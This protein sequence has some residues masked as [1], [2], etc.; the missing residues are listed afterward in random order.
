M[1]GNAFTQYIGLISLHRSTKIRVKQY[2]GDF[3]NLHHT[4]VTWVDLTDD[5]N[6]KQ[7]NHHAAVGQFLAIGQW[8][9]VYCGEEP[10]AT[11]LSTDPWWLPLRTLNDTA[12]VRVKGWQ[13]VYDPE[14]ETTP[15][16]YGFHNLKPDV[17]TYIY[18]GYV[19]YDED[20]SY[21]RGLADED[22]WQY[23]LRQLGHHNAIGQYVVTDGG[24]SVN[25][26]GL[27][28]TSHVRV[29]DSQFETLRTAT[30]NTNVVKTPV[31]TDISTSAT[32]GSLT[33]NTTYYYVV[34]P[35]VTINGDTFESEYSQSVS[36][37]TGGTA[38]NEI[39]IFQL[40]SEGEG[41]YSFTYDF[42]GS[43]EFTTAALAYDATAAQIKTAL[44][45]GFNTEFATTGV[46]Y[47]TTSTGSGPD[48]DITIDFSNGPFAGQNIPALVANNI[49]LNAEATIGI[50]TDTDGGDY[51][52]TNTVT[53]SWDKIDK[54]VSYNVYRSEDNIFDAWPTTDGFRVGNTTSTTITD[55]GSSTDNA[56]PDPWWWKGL[57]YTDLNNELG[58]NTLNH[59]TAIGQYIV[60]PFNLSNNNGD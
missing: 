7:L 41:T 57:V 46:Q 33:G 15:N 25:I 13:A 30:T 6:L 40:D 52:D 53:L 59:H 18:I 2:G 34:T 35:V 58:R 26:Q 42:E 36:I 24:S 16:I 32:G 29:Y 60:W 17:T 31:I 8:S 49:D 9:D 12:R 51:T 20:G 3:V 5:Y 54:A 47:V 45:N 14:T 56:I 37:T 23:N 1:S 55:D 44:N 10:P 4:N 21:A 38:S 43:H 39:Q 27:N 11:D 19:P 48:Y 28:D 50:V 22:D